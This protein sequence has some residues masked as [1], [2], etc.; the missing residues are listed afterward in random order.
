M[1]PTQIAA[2]PAPL[3]GTASD[4]KKIAISDDEKMAFL[5]SLFVLA[6]DPDVYMAQINQ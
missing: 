2:A 1:T 4:A 5:V 6:I 3:G